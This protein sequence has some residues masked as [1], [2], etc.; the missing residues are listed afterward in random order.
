MSNATKAVRWRGCLA[1]PHPAGGSPAVPFEL[2]GRWM[3]GPADCLVLLLLA[4][5][6]MEH[7]SNNSSA[8][9]AIHRALA[10]VVGTAAA[11]CTANPDHPFETYV[12]EGSP[13]PGAC[14][15]CSDDGQKCVEV[16]EA[17]QGGQ[18]SCPGEASRRFIVHGGSC[19]PGARAAP[20]VEP[21][22]ALKCLG[23]AC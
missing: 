17:A 1:D 19:H 9:P 2:A 21:A 20:A 11:A 12:E 3:V 23:C 14:Y 18:P 4:C 22:H 5:V 16:G 13:D 15:K 10:A 8:H 6:L 7:T